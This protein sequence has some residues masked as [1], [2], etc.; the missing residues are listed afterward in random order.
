M[1][2]NSLLIIFGIYVFKTKYIT[3]WHGVLR[4][5]STY[6][7]TSVPDGTH[8]YCSDV[9]GVR[10]NFGKGLKSLRDLDRTF[11]PMKNWSGDANAWRREVETAIGRIKSLSTCLLASSTEFE[12]SDAYDSDV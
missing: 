10:R 9:G 2:D 4:V 6:S 5:A 8:L 7:R 11:E 3:Q 12:V 1:K